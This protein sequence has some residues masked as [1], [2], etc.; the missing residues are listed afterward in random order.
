MKHDDPIAPSE[1]E[2]DTL[3][4][5]AIRRAELLDERMPSAARA[6]WREVMEFEERL[7][8]I[9][10]A[11]EISGGI[12]RVGAIQAAL[13]AGLRQDA[14]QLQTKYLLD[15]NLS[16]ERK[17]AIERAFAS[18]QARQALRYPSLANKGM[19]ARLGELDTWRMSMA[20]KPRVFPI[21]A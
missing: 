3:V 6:A 14:K 12:A 8:A 11:S 13:A 21:A 5:I 20:S 18:D 7:A 2:L 10:D 19:L 15:K 16:T 9:S 1:D 17:A 4:S